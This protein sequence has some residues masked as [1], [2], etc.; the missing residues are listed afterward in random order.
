MCVL[1]PDLLDIVHAY[2]RE[3][4]EPMLRC[5]AAIRSYQNKV[6]CFGLNDAIQTGLVM[7]DIVTHRLIFTAM[8]ALLIR[9][10]LAY[11]AD[12]NTHT[13]WQRE[14]IKFEMYHL[15]TYPEHNQE[16]LSISVFEHWDALIDDLFAT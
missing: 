11:G 16:V 3:H 12:V 7:P 10:L 4:L 6:N 8:E 14:L 1:I 15:S 2:A 13:Y 5:H 9:R